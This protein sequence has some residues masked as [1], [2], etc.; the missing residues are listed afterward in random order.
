[1]A[2]MRDRN[3]YTCQHFR[4]NTED[5][6]CHNCDE[7]YSKWKSIKVLAENDTVEKPNHYTAGKYETIDI[8]ADQVED[9]KSY[10]HGNCIK[11]LS[12]YRFKN[13]VED[14]KKC[15]KYLEWLIVEV[16]N[17]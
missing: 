14:L 10:L 3:C 17:E 6:P 7:F 13:G 16:G 5:R 15:K 1:M 2:T 12:R 11:Y 8:I 4:V 9:Y